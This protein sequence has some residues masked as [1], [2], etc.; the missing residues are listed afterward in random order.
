[1]NTYIV[2]HVASDGFLDK[3]NKEESGVLR[4]KDG[5]YF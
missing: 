2:K 1:M 5:F 4:M 3:Y